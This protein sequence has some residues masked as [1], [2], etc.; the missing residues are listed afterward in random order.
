MPS[1]RF[2]NP[3][4]LPLINMDQYYAR[5]GFAG[6]RAPTLPMLRAVLERHTQVIPFENLTPL[7]GQPVE[8]S[9]SA[10]AGKL[11]QDRRGGYCF[12]HNLLLWNVLH[13]LG[14]VVQGLAA[15]V[16]WQ[17]PVGSQTA[18]THMLLLVSIDETDYLADVGFGGSTPS[19]PLLLAADIEQ[20]SAQDTYR[21]IAQQDLHELQLRVRDAWWPMYQFNLTHYY[22]GD[23]QIMNWYTSTSPDSKFTR[24]LSAARC[25]GSGRH[26]LRDN[27]YTWRQSDGAEQRTLLTH[28]DDIKQVLDRHLHI[29]VPA[30]ATLDAQLARIAALPAA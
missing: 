8:L 10:L 9:T 26:T 3:P 11:L 14:F 5:I 28:G 15:R 16:R 29:T 24:T 7:A 12:E 22:S 30:S 23:Y 4:F 13:Q 21:L 17:A 25:D 19:V 1:S 27:L 2:P 6:T 20:H 18:L